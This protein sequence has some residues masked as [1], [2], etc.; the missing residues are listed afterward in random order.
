MDEVD[1]RFMGRVIKCGD[2][3]SRKPGN[4]TEFSTSKWYVTPMGRRDRFLD[5]F[6][7]PLVVKEMIVVRRMSSSSSKSNNNNPNSR[8]KYEL[9]KGRIYSDKGRTIVLKSFGWR[10]FT[11]S[12]QCLWNELIVFFFFFNSSIINL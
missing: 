3:V 12:G 2:H 6:L 5:M 1:T 9:R 8:G 11:T 4:E 10:Q 7:F